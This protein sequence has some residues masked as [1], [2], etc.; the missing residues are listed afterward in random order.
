MFWSKFSENCALTEL[1]NRT[2]AIKD[3]SVFIFSKG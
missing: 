3:K 2:E 1:M